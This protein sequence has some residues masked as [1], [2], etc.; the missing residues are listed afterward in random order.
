MAAKKKAKKA[1]AKKVPNKKAT[2]KRGRGRP[3][4]YTK[5]AADEICNR[6]AGGESLR[7]ICADPKLPGISTVMRWLFDESKKEFWEHYARAREIQ[8]ER[9]ADEILEI[10]D[11][12]TNDW[13]ERELQN[14]SSVKVVD[15]EHV[16][17]SKLRVDSRKWLMSKLLPKKYGDKVSQEI[18]GPDGGAIQVTAI[19]RRIV[20]P[21]DE[22]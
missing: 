5:E 9:W 12:G 20:D 15:H 1:P 16:S 22:A 7:Q 18:T 2:E 10:A 4:A 21:K 6:L 11:D 17:R 14:G 3:E 13:V 19:T 8:A